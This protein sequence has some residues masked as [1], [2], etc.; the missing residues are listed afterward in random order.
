M[1]LEAAGF[2]LEYIIPTQALLSISESTPAYAWE[3]SG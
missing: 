2:T 3:W 1:L